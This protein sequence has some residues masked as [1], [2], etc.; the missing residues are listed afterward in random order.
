MLFPSRWVAYVVPA[1]AA[2]ATCFVPASVA[3]ADDKP[4][5]PQAPRFPFGEEQAKQ[6]RD[7]YAK[8]AGLPKEV[9]NSV[10]MK[11]VLIP[12]GNFEMGPNGSK[13]RVT[14]SKPF[15]AGVTEVTLGQYRKF[16]AGHKVDGADDEFRQLVVDLRGEIE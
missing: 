6:F 13:Y 3:P 5:L 8:A 10:G 15:H 1:C 16:K 4:K 12:P 2:L 14:L 9:T 7:D 11:M